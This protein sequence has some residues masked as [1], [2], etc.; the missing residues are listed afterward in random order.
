MADF[1]YHT[2]RFQYNIDSLMA[3]EVKKTVLMEL[4]PRVLRYSGIINAR[5]MTEPLRDGIWLM[6]VGIQKNYL[7]PAQAGVHID[8]LKEAQSHNDEA[9]FGEKI[10]QTPATS[11]L[12]V[13]DSKSARTRLRRLGIDV[14]QREF[15]STQTAFVRSTDGVIIQPVEFS[16]QDLRMMR[17]RSNF[18]IELQ[19]VDERKLQVENVLR[20]NFGKYLQELNEKR[21]LLNANLGK[22]VRTTI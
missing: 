12:Q 10:L 17:V 6:K 9:D 18:L 11:S 16:M 5:K 8:A 15:I 20:G 4:D 19:P 7:D 14:P 3:L 2:V 1:G 13:K 22:Q 21:K